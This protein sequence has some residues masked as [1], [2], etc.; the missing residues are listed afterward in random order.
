MKK[1][2]ERLTI[3]VLLVCASFCGAALAKDQ[4]VRVF[5]N[6]RAMKLKPSALMRDGKAYVGLR[7]VAKALGARARWDEK[8]K[9]AVITLGNKRTRVEQSKGIT[10]AGQLF[11]PLRVVGEAVGCTVHWDRSVRAVRITTEG[12]CPIGGG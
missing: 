2:L 6:D 11:L 10:I 5:V 8:S 1:H 12:P 3:A 7:G 9:T 4:P